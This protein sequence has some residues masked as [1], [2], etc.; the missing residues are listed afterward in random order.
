MPFRPA[1]S[2][3]V[4]LSCLLV[5]GGC[6]ES[7]QITSYD[8][9]R[10]E[11]DVARPVPPRAVAPANAEPQR[12]LVATFLRGGQAWF[13]KATA[14]PDVIAEAAGELRGFVDQIEL[15]DAEPDQIKWP[16]PE[17]W[18]SIPPT[19][20]FRTATLVMP[21]G[22]EVAISKIAY[23]GNLDEFLLPNVNRWRGQVGLAPVDKV[24]SAAGV[25]TIEVAG[26]TVWMF[27]ATGTASSGGM[28]APFAGGGMA[29][30]PPISD[31]PAAPAEK[32]DAPAAKPELKVAIPDNWK[33][34]EA[35]SMG[36]KS[37]QV[38]EGDTQATY[39]MSDFT[40]FGMMGD[41]LF[42]VNR[43]RG[44]LGLG[45]I[46]QP[47]LDELAETIT[48]GGTEGLVATMTSDDQSKRMIAAMV[49]KGGQAWF[50]QLMGTP[51]AVDAHRDAF[52][53]LLSEADIVLPGTT[54]EG[55]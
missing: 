34:T 30:H 33:F 1:C 18:K 48:I 19:S 22:L 54:G 47:K 7:P 25:E 13:V 44:Q 14:A 46:D 42:N 32:P 41:P 21:S 43:W 24:D 51:Q 2:L 37:Y 26:Q 16:V 3:I 36:S 12:M 53:K 5:T 52:M 17:G 45:E 35:G 39:K 50:F 27:D 8:V 4:V 20:A 11:G 49:V 38:G 55:E 23:P 15:P 6:N 40:A 29:G 9:A 10:D 31:T 28:M